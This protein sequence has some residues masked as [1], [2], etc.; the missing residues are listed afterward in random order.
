MCV[1]DEMRGEREKN[2]FQRKRTDRRTGWK[3]GVNGAEEWPDS[4]KECGHSARSGKRVSG[5]LTC[6]SADGSMDH[7]KI[8]GYISVL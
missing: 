4:G 2:R 5:V 7:D 1:V 6:T 3:S 8:T